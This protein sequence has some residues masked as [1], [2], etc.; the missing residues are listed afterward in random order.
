M[1]WLQAD[2]TGLMFAS[3]H[4]H[5]DVASAFIDASCDID[6]FGTVCS[7]FIFLSPIF[8]EPGQMSGELM[9]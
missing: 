4:N 2:F 7:Y 8:S 6:A 5:P 3:Y 1:I 9:S